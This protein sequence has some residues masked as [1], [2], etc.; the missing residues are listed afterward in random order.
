MAADNATDGYEA[1]AVAYEELA[2]ITDMPPGDRAKISSDLQ[3][4]LN[5]LRVR[6][7]ARQ[8]RLSQ[9]SLQMQEAE[10]WAQESFRNEQM[11]LLL[12]TVE[13]GRRQAIAM[14][15]IAKEFFELVRGNGHVN[16]RNID[17]S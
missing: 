2:N 13:L 3:L 5:A 10:R 7:E 11:R 9:A 15:S 14:E 17:D 4:K 16:V 1:I 12:E 6:E 8:I